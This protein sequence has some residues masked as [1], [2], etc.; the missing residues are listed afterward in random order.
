MLYMEAILQMNNIIKTYPGFFQH[1][2][3]ITSFPMMSNELFTFGRY[4]KCGIQ[5]E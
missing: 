3:R 1:W 4:D 2:L 5:L